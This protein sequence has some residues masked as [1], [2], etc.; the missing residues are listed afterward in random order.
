MDPIQRAIGLHNAQAHIN[1]TN[2]TGTPMTSGRMLNP[3]EEETGQEVVLR[4]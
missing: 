4:Q 1:T 3:E 2:A